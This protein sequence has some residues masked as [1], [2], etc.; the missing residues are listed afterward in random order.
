MMQVRTR[1][2]IQEVGN[3]DGTPGAIFLCDGKR[4][5][6]TGLTEHEVRELGKRLYGELYI[7][8]ADFY[9]SPE[10]RSPEPKA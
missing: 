8:I 4:V 6:V 10:Q 5:T 2:Q 3:F 1:V 7:T 9:S